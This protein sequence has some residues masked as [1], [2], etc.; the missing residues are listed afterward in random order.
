[1]VEGPGGL[2]VRR[3]GK[4]LEPD[5]LFPRIGSTIDDFELSVARHLEASG[6]CLFNDTRSVEVA[7]D[8]FF[9]LQ[10][11]GGAGVSVPRTLLL[12]KGSDA[13]AAVDFLGGFPLV[14]KRRRGRKGRGVALIDNASALGFVLDGLN[15]PG[16]AVLLQE[17]LR[18]DDPRDVRVLVMEGRVLA[19]MM[20]KPRPGDFRSNLGQEGEPL[21][22]ELSDMEIET[23]V[24]AASATGLDL[25]GVDLLGTNSGT[26]V[27]E[28]NYTPGLNTLTRICGVDVGGEVVRAAVAKRLR[29]RG[30]A[31]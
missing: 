5:I 6:V 12:T 30:T 24:R 23:A 26:V 1:M 3:D 13:R 15:G 2:S 16:E 21:P 11:L 22:V 17:F 28:V 8:K 18:A 25:A 10:K 20:K 4:R 27:L 7:R 29:M 14:V 9:S 19:A 31:A